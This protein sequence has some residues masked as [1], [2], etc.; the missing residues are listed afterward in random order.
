[1]RDFSEDTG[2]TATTPNFAP[3]AGKA[4]AKRRHWLIGASFLVTVLLPVALTAAYLYQ[5]AVDQYVSRVGFVVR[6]EETTPTIDLLGGL[7]DLSSAS[8]TDR[9]ILREFIHSP[10]LVQSIDSRLNLRGIYSRHRASDP[11]FSVAPDVPIEGLV[12]YWERMINVVY[13]PGSELIELRV[14]AFSAAEAQLIA[15]AIFVDSTNMINALNNA[16]RRDATKTASEELAV[17]LE[18]L[19]DAR[20]ALF[21]FRNENQIVD[22]V[23]D[24][25][26][27]MGVI[28]T[29]QQQLASA[30]V[31]LD[32]QMENSG[33]TNPRVV[34]IQRRIEVIEDRI[35]TE[36]AKFGSQ[37]GES[38]QAYAQIVGEYERLVVELEFAERRHTAAQIAYDTAQARAQQQSRYLAPYMTPTLAESPEYPQRAKTL[39][40][41]FLLSL[42]TWI[43]GVLIYYAVRDRR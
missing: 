4:P 24:L 12:A 23:N 26:V 39:A 8:S 43:S 37:S 41:V 29:L 18:S 3:P 21:R 42:I 6:S 20:A 1:M 14:K 10:S 33:S 7:T 9:D 25:Q 40:L 16:A 30:F 34:Q 11:L 2:E 35:A 17:S 38:G 36:R 28:N 5:Y 31:D 27:L 32:L 22:P 13:D 19:K 15:Y